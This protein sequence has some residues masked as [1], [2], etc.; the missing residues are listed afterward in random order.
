MHLHYLMNMQQHVGMMRIKYI[1]IFIII[2]L[3]SSYMLNK[4]IA[5]YLLFV[6]IAESLVLHV[7]TSCFPLFFCT[8]SFLPCFFLPP[9]VLHVTD[10][11]PLYFHTSC[12][13]LFLFPIKLENVTCVK[14]KNWFVFLFIDIWI[15]FSYTYQTLLDQSTT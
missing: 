8:T 15:Y 4:I 5:K 1:T 14:S 10:C 7:S 13:P 6:Q 3:Y 9:F 2:I 11:F 12:S